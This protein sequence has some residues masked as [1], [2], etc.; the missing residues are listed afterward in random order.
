MT[1]AFSAG[2]WVG[3]RQLR[4]VA[5]NIVSII[6]FLVLCLLRGDSGP[7]RYGERTNAPAGVR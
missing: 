4:P 5:L 7:N 3:E 2:R 6:A 1:P